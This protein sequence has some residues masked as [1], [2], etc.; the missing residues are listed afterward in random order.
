MPDAK[1]GRPVVVNDSGYTTP[2]IARLLK[3]VYSME[4]DPQR[5]IEW[6]G[7]HTQTGYPKLTWRY[8]THSVRR[9]IFGIFRGLGIPWTGS[10]LTM[11]CGNK[12]CVNPRHMS[13]G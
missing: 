11:R 12:N 9:V 8:K 6:W 5:C 10:N 13:V 3:E 4:E 2:A 1:R 7:S